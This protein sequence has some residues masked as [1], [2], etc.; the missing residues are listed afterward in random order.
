[1]YMLYDGGAWCTRVASFDRARGCREIVWPLYVLS[2]VELAGSAHYA[3][4]GVCTSW[5]SFDL[6]LSHHTKHVYLMLAQAT[7]KVCKDMQYYVSNAP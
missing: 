2:N 5:N 3:I 7:M 1:M 6:T 4:Y